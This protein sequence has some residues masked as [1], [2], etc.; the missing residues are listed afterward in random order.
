MTITIDLSAATLE[1]L[2][3]EAQAT[4][5]N[6]EAVVRDAIE[7]KLARRKRTFAEIMRPIHDEVSASGMSEEQVTA[8]LEKE[9]KAV[10]AERRTGHAK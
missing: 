2:K 5:K 9:L 6:V 4:G 3:A 1:R 10:R 7:E 8:L